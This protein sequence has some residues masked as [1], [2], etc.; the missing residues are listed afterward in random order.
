VNEST[1]SGLDLGP[2]F[3]LRLVTPRLELRLPDEDEL[4][5]LAHLAEQG[6]HPPEEM[7]FFVAWTDGIGK[8]GFVESFVAFHRQQRES[9]SPE[10]WHLLLGVWSGGEVMG[11]QGLDA[12]DFAV[13]RTA[14]TGSWLGQRFQGRG[15]G[16]EMRAAMLEL[17]FGGLGG[18]VATS[19]ALDG[20]V[21]SERVS[22]KLGYVRSGEGVAS[23]RGVPV[24]QQ[25]F[26]LEREVWAA[27]DHVPV[28]IH[29]LEP[30]LPLFG[31]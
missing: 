31:L 13:S 12:K 4:D 8:P 11:T 23:P 10:Q 9:W 2:L 21:A 3:G 15:F 26:R 17:L 1:G 28:E 22:E 27:R 25:H 14:E 16:T 24:R 29:G 20:N 5:E 30:C 18:R 6:V 7:P 19:G